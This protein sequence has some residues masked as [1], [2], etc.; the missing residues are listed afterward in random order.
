MVQNSLEDILKK[1]MKIIYR[2]L[3]RLGAN[4]Q[5]AED[6]VQETLYKTILYLDS[7]EI[8]KI[9]AWTFRVA[10]NQYYDLSRKRKRLQQQFIDFQNISVEEWGLP[11]FQII[12]KEKMNQVKNI[13]NQLS[14]RYKQVL[15]LKYEMELS[16]AQ[17]SAMLDIPLPSLKTILYRGRKQFVELYRRIVDETK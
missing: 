3:I 16:Y 7:I 17:I 13:L 11:E 6:L 10:T 5:D 8:N 2:Y 1:Q 9:S 15:L 4:S 12:Q 14:P